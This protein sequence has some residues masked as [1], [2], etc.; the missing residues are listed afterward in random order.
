M[1]CGRNDLLNISIRAR[2]RSKDDRIKQLELE[3]RRLKIAPAEAIGLVD[4]QY[5]TDVK[6]TFD[7]G[8]FS[9]FGIR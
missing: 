6:K 1:K 9:I 3:N 2:M 4:E 5:Q 8:C 7:T